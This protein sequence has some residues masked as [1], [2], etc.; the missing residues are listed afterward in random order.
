MRGDLFKEFRRY[1][2]IF[3]IYIMGSKA[4]SFI[5]A[6]LYSYYMTTAEYGTMDIISTTTVLLFPFVCLDIFEAAFRFANKDS[7]NNR[8]V[9]SSTLAIGILSN[10][11]IWAILAIIGLIYKLPDVA[12]FCFA[13]ASLDSIFHIVLHYA[14][15]KGEMLHFAL[16]GIINSVA[17]LLLNI[18]F[19]VCL[20][21]GLYGWIISL[22]GAKVIST[23]YIIIASNTFSEFRIKHVNKKIC[24]E[25][26]KYCLPLMPSASMWWIMN[27]SDR[28]VITWFLGVS[29]TGIYAVSNKLPAILSIFENIFYQSWQTTAI[30]NLN[31]SDRDKIYSEVFFKYFKILSFG[32]LGIL[33][34]LKPFILHLF[35]QDYHDAWVCSSVLVIGVMVHALAGNLGT[36]YVAFKSTTG[37][38]KTSAIGA[39]SNIILNVIFVQLYGMNAAAWTTLIGYII[40]L[41]IRLIDTSKFVKLTIPKR[42]TVFL[43]GCI[44]ISFCL[45]YFDYWW[46]YAIRIIIVLFVLTEI[47]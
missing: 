41:V 10:V 30:N 16:G 25:A 37:A 17:M 21:L 29:A 15:G 46:S 47:Y 3:G 24:K 42:D 26:V 2:L 14:R 9:I 12:Y 18:A 28:Y 8:A 11:I 39:V 32:V 45:Y 34:F 40:V 7:V 6:P 27:A 20:K 22:V 38:L 4:I 43:T 5:L 44:L 19:L 23:V 13:F 31:N 33:V 1:N 35:A 36:L